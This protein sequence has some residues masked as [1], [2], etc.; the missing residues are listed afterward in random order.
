MMAHTADTM[1]VSAGACRR[2]IFW[3]VGGLLY[4]VTANRGAVGR[5]EYKTT[6]DH[7]LFSP[8][9]LGYTS[10]GVDNIAHLS[11]L[12]IGFVLA[13]IFIS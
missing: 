2:Q 4:V 6:C 8:L 9:Y 13:I 11:G 1:T 3:R 12:V 10:T 5:S 7:D